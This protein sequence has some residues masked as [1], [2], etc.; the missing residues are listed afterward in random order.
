MKKKKC[1]KCDRQ[2]HLAFYNRDKKGRDGLR[3]NCL[4]CQ[5]KKQ[6]ESLSKRI[7]EVE[8]CITKGRVKP[9]LTTSRQ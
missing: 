6:V 9:M 5:Y 7:E 3:A 4:S 8:K 1:S 2:L